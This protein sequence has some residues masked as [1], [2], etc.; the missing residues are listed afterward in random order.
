MDNVP[1][2]EVERVEPWQ[3]EGYLRRLQARGTASVRWN[4]DQLDI[5]DALRRS[6]ALTPT[7]T[8]VVDGQDIYVA[9][10]DHSADDAPRVSPIQLG[11]RRP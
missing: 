2:R 9:E 6:K 10:P 8:V 1:S 5:H 4:R 3:L 11:P 7:A